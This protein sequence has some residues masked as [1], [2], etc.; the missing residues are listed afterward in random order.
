MEAQSISTQA[1]SSKELTFNEYMRLYSRKKYEEKA[2]MIH[3]CDICDKDIK[4]NCK[5]HHI[6]T[7]LHKRN[8]FIK[9]QEKKIL[10]QADIINKFI[11][12]K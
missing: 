11:Q 10:E 1:I 8:L 12:N 3:H 6:R 5:A 4:E 7:N 2:N 9:E